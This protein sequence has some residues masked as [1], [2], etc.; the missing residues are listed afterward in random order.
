MREEMNMRLASKFW[1]IL[2]LGAVLLLTSEIAAQ[3][4]PFGV[5]VRIVNTMGR[6]LDVAGAINANGTNVQIWDCNGSVAQIWT[7]SP[8]GQIRNTMGRCLDVS[9]AINVQGGNV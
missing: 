2:S 9:G 5:P 6:C 7:L 4:Q 1:K 8:G 3:A